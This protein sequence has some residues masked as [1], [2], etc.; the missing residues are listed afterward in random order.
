MITTL[1]RRSFV[2]G[3]AATLAFAQSPVPV[4][5]AF[6]HILL[7]ISDL[8]R[9]IE[10]LE[11][12]SGV[13]AVFG[14]VHPGRGTRNAL[15]SLGGAHYLEIIALDPAQPNATPQFPIRGLTEPRLINFAVRT[16]DINATAARLQAAD[17]KTNGPKPGSR[18]TASGT[19]LQWKA[20]GVESNFASGQINPIPFFIEWATDSKHPSEDAPRGCSIQNIAFEHPHA[21]ELAAFL[22]TL[23]LE[24]K[25]AK[26]D[27]A[28]IFARI[29]SPKGHLELT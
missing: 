20:L 12:R 22:H 26:A 4:R 23:G 6:D 18:R 14:G 7:G 3:S 9:G 16:K 25:V 5:D 27:E 15:I 21:S 11:K 19:L 10:W 13:R 24:A 2:S 1:T 8:D 29:Q 17:V 28:R